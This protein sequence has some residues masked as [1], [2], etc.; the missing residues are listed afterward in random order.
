[1][2]RRWRRGWRCIRR[3]CSITRRGNLYRLYIWI[4]LFNKI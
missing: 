3:R 1:L 4:L 2:R